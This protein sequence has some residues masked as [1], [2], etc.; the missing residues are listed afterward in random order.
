MRP[1]LSWVTSSPSRRGQSCRVGGR[2]TG[3]ATRRSTICTAESPDDAAR[4][5]SHARCRHDAEHYF[6]SRPVALTVIGPPHHPHLEAARRRGCAAGSTACVDSA[7]GSS[8]KEAGGRCARS[9]V[10]LRRVVDRAGAL[11]RLL[12]P[13]TVR[14]DVPADVT[15]MRHDATT[16]PSELLC[17]NAGRA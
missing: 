10:V 4:A 3:V 13:P 12:M 14:I 17:V 16:S 15:L 9:L 7:P 11:R 5:C 1:E 2:G 8:D 6:G